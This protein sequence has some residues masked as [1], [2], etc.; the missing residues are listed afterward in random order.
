M[1]SF[2]VRMIDIRWSVLRKSQVVKIYPIM[3]FVTRVVVVFVVFCLESGFFCFVCSEWKMGERWSGAR[4]ILTRCMWLGGWHLSQS[5]RRR[6]DLSFGVTWACA[7]ILF[8]LGPWLLSAFIS[9]VTRSSLSVACGEWWGTSTCATRVQF[10]QTP[11]TT[12]TQTWRR[13]SSMKIKE[14][15]LWT[16][17][18]TTLVQGTTINT[19]HVCLLYAFCLS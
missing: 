7:C 9:S 4:E 11:G 12:H 13:G 18:R 5:P 6:G 17:L 1:K 10:Y 16:V 3:D 19:H 14:I 15:Y 2:S 8:H